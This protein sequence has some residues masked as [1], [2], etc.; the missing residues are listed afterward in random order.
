MP[1]DLAAGIVG[2]TA[3][4]VLGYIAGQKINS[5]RR[6]TQPVRFLVS[7]LFALLFAWSLSGSLGWAVI[8]PDASVVTWS[9]LMPVL[10]C[11]TAGLASRAPGLTSWRRPAVIAPLSMLAIGYAL[12]PAVR[13]LV[14]P[15]QMSRSTTWNGDICLQSHP[16]TC[17]PAAA[18]TLLRLKGIQ[19]DEAAMGAACLT[20][21]HGTEPLGLYRGLTAVARKRGY[22]ARVA[23]SHPSDWIDRGQLPC[24]ALVRFKQTHSQRPLERLLGPRGEGHAV[25]ILGRDDDG[26]WQ[27]A[28]PAFGKTTWSDED[29]QR[30]FTGDAIYLQRMR[31]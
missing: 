19:A 21:R 31:D 16:A 8:M 13:P 12:M 1:F 28:D 14:V 5:N 22:A 4:S 6:S 2:I 30:R 10:L 23:G 25:V 18:T 15:A 26:D 24:I 17:A 20:S 7:L 3:L 11:F 27:I 9:N 29:L